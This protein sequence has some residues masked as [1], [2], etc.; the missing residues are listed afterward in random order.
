[1]LNKELH[2]I[3]HKETIRKAMETLTSLGE[4]LTLFVINENNQL[5]GVVT[6]GNIRRG[7]VSGVKIDDEVREIMNINF[8][9]LFENKF[10][11]EEIVRLREESV[12][13]IPLIDK[14]FKIK[15]IENIF[16]SPDYYEK[17]AAQTGI[18]NLKLN[19]NN[20]IGFYVETNAQNASKLDSN[21]IHRQT[22]ANAM[23]FSTAELSELESKIISA[24]DQA[25]QLELNIFN[26]LSEE[27]KANS[28]ALL[29]TAR[30]LAFVDVVAG[31]AELGQKRKYT[32]PKVDNS[33]N[34][35]IEK[36]RHPVVEAG[37]EFI[38]NDCNLNIS[39]NLWLLTGPNMAGKS[40][41]LR[42]NALIAILA[43]IGSF[44]S[45]KA[46]HIGCVDR[47]FSR[48][49]ASDNLNKGQSTFMVEMLE[50]AQILNH[51]TEKSLVILDEIGRGTATYDGLSIAWAVLEY[52]HN[53]TRARAIFATHYH[54]L[55]K[56]RLERL[57][58]YSMQVKEWDGKI[59]FLHEVAAGA[60]NRSYGIHVA[61]LAGVPPSVTKRAEA[62]L[63]QLTEQSKGE[64]S[65]PLFE[66]KAT[67]PNELEI[68]LSAISPDELSP[69]E[70][71]E[72]LYALKN[73][74]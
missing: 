39:Q 21:F 10:S 25:L 23:R 17:Y 35:H 43:Q 12:K 26:E 53:K 57:A 56:L 29:A 64:Q 1:M 5:V 55:T 18:S 9:Y 33:T 16:A 28:E 2:I 74:L 44:V 60:A 32:R 67:P 51:A 68:A 54:E 22:M 24:R 46:A 40:T 41:F 73:L 71:L 19:H 70:A 30:A 49:G 72:K 27:V 50:T 52:L 31:L 34:F 42:Q 58:L 38:A 11:F 6:D 59:V 37:V 61:K 13:I 66:S 36:G 14:E 7:L 62:V 4:N 15:R 48:V 20:V 69:K 8:K 3:S 63:Q 45:A 65:L 47:I